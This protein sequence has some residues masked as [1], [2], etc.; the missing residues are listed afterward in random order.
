MLILFT[1]ILRSKNLLFILILIYLYS[2]RI[3]YISIILLIGVYKIILDR[4]RMYCSILVKDIFTSCFNF[5]HNFNDLPTHNTIL[6]VTYPTTILE[7]LSQFIFP[8][9]ISIVASQRS[10]SLLKLVYEDENIITFN[11]LKRKQYELLKNKIKRHIKY[12][13]IYVYVDDMSTRYHQFHVGK[14]RKGMFFIAKELGITITPVVID[15]IISSYGNIHSQNFEIKIGKTRHV[16]NPKN[17]IVK[18][19]NFFLKTK[20][21]F[22][23]YKYR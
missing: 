19:R 11:N 16:K 8:I 9:K 15:G 22:K 13:S 4:R 1:I 17:E 14:L 6:L 10:R 23:K 18:C 7:Y 3:L 5:K 12:S 21:S 20:R 2:P